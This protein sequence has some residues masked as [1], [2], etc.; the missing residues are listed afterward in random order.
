MQ[1]IPIFG[2]WLG[3]TQLQ[4]LDI[5]AALD[6]VKMIDEQKAMDNGTTITQR[7]LDAPLF[8]DV[9]AECELLSK[10]YVDI[11]GHQVDQVK[12]ASSWG[13]VLRNNQP[14]HVHMHPNSYVSGVFYLTEGA[15]L[16]FHNPLMT[17]DLFTLRP[18]VRWD[19]TNPHTWQVLKVPIK[20]GYIFLFPSKLNHHVDENHTDYRYSIAF[21]TMP[22][23]LIGDSTKELNI[24]K[25][26]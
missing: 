18:V 24:V 25:V 3:F 20:P 22:T 14:I 17:E 26:E 1:M 15:P 12:I 9:K 10:T 19:E 4:S 2:A 21:N 8:K 23:G 5:Q 16:N 11:Q 7:L 13:N 6:Y